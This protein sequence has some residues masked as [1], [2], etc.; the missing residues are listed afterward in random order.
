MLLKK[1]LRDVARAETRE[2]EVSFFIGSEAET[3]FWKTEN[4]RVSLGEA[5]MLKCRFNRMSPIDEP[6]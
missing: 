4:K 1:N 3:M 2:A 5:N 6:C